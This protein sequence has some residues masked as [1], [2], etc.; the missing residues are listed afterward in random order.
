MRSVWGWGWHGWF[1]WFLVDLL[2]YV[3]ELVCV[4]VVQ[5]YPVS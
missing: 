3:V 2:Q 4:V 5:A 1:G